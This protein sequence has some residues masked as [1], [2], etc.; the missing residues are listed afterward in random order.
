MM[1]E[2]AQDM[3]SSQA[4]MGAK[5]AKLKLNWTHSDFFFN[6]PFVLKATTEPQKQF[7]WFTLQQSVTLFCSAWRCNMSPA[8]ARAR[9]QKS[10]LQCTHVMPFLFK[11]ASGFCASPFWWACCQGHTCLSFFKLRFLHFGETTRQQQKDATP[12]QRRIEQICLSDPMLS[13]WKQKRQLTPALNKTQPSW[14]H[15]S[16]WQSLQHA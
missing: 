2:P 16:L 3:K 7:H 14:H 13:H 12:E 6:S 15:R 10:F 11:N 9:M 8:I 4:S 1:K 5:L